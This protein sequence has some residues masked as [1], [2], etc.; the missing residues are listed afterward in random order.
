MK[1]GQ[2]KTADELRMNSKQFDKIMRRALQAYS[3]EAPKLKKSIKTKT[4]GVQ[5]TSRVA[6]S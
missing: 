6:K 5:R 2:H 4:K 1:A 3:E